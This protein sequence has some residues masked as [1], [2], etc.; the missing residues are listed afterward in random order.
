MVCTKG[1]LQHTVDRAG[2]D[3]F[4]GD[5]REVEVIHH[6]KGNREIISLHKFIAG[7]ILLGNG[8]PTK[9]APPPP[10]KEV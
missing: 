8:G 2:G 6:G 5:L 7:T 3:K 1:D 9:N 4:T 10:D